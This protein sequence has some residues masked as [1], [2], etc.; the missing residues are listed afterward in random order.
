MDLTWPWLGLAL[1][2]A[3]VVVLLLASRHAGRHH[4]PPA[5]PVL[6][7]HSERV[8]RLPRFHALARSAARLARW[9]SIAVV[10]AAAGAILLAARPAATSVSQTSHSTRDIVLC[11]DASASMLDEDA[12]VIAAFSDI[13]DELH[14]ERIS[15]V[16]WSDAAVTVFPLTDDYAFVKRQLDQAAEAFGS[17]VGADDYAAGTYLNRDRAS[18]ISDGIVS[19]VQRFDQSAGARGRAVVVTSD[20]EPWGT[21]PPLYTLA[22]ASTYA[23]RHHVR[24][25]GIGAPDLAYLPEQRTEFATAMTDSGGTFSLLGED[26][27]VDSIVAGIRRLHTRT[28]LDPPVISRADRPG[29]AIA[30]TGVGVTMLLAGWTVALVRRPG[31]PRVEEAGR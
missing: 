26:R 30:L 28:V 9:Q 8:R 13:V 7:A 24:L 12:D 27:S 1:A 3:L 21:S 20:N 22:E 11:M 25:Y 2:A 29:M 18:I 31:R 5:D 15:L 16:L 4:R 23:Q 19:C 17:L 10:I 14:G 6:I